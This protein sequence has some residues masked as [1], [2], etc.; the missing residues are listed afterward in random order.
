MA[1]KTA[2]VASLLALSPVLLAQ[3][4]LQVKRASPGDVATGEVQ[5]EDNGQLQLALNPCGPT[6]IVVIFQRPYSTEPAGTV[7]CDG[8]QKA[9]VQVVKK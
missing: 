8:V 3:G 7:S 9:L 6:Q 4:V 2:Y 5:R 1:R